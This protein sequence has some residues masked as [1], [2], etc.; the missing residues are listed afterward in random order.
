M[1][2]H[3]NSVSLLHIH[4]VYM[5]KSITLLS[6]SNILSCPE[7]LLR[8]QVQEILLYVFLHS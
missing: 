6:E 4:G 3:L 7:Y 1:F 8:A 2:V 5:Y